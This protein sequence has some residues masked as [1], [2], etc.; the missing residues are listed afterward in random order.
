MTQQ[1]IDRAVSWRIPPL[2]ERPAPYGRRHRSRRRHLAA[3][4]AL[5]PAGA[6]PQQPAHL[7]NPAAR[8]V[9][10]THLHCVGAT[11]AGITRRPVPPS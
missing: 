5:R 2:S 8:A 7:D 4:G 9:Q 1:L 6:L 3:H 11:P 10:R